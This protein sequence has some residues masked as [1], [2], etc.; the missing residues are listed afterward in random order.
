MRI[1]GRDFR[2]SKGM[3]EFRTDGLG[4]FLVR[5]KGQRK[6]QRQRRRHAFCRKRM[7]CERCIKEPS[8]RNIAL[9][10]KFQDHAPSRNIHG[11]PVNRDRFIPSSATFPKKGVL[12]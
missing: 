4:I 9:A 5:E 12:V 2:A 3:V 8:Q 10:L 6:Q 7:Y 1:L 11:L